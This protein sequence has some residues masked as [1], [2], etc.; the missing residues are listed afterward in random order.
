MS[1]PD[2]TALGERLSSGDLS[3]APEVLNLVENRTPAARPQIAALLRRLSPA[4]LGGE[5]PGHIVGV[6]GPPGAGK[7][8]LLSELVREWR[9]AG[10]Q[11]R[12]ARRRPVVAAQRRLAARRPR[13]DR[14]R[15]VRRQRVHPLDR[16]RR[17]P[18]R[19]GAGDARGRRVAR[20]RLR[21]RRRRDRRR[22]PERDGRRRGR[23]HRRRRSCSPPPATRCSSSRAGSWRSPTCSS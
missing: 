9:A 11:R 5:A 8:T 15:P 14:L 3:A 19:P 13:A 6:T 22:R 12:R 7:S 23:R 21:R 18:R 16:R 2:G 4:A 10:L 17:P 20:G 1:L